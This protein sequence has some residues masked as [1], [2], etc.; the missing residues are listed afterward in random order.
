MPGG[1]L[2]RG[3]FRHD[4]ALLMATPSL[5]LRAL[6]MAWRDPHD[7]SGGD[8]GRHRSAGAGTGHAALG[9]GL[10]RRGFYLLLARVRL[11]L[12]RRATRV[13]PEL[14]ERAIPLLRCLRRSRKG[15]PSLLRRVSRTRSIWTNATHSARRTM[16]A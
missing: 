13:A 4:Q 2:G 16:Q 11:A 10:W 9:S 14:L 3:P 12:F 7:R 8:G 6:R 1:G 5:C 15:W